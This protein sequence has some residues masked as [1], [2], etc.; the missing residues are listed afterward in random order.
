M[1]QVTKFCM[2]HAELVFVIAALIL[3]FFMQ[4]DETS[5][6]LCLFNWL[7]ISW[8]PGCG[9]GHSIHYALHANFAASVHHHILGIPAVI[10]ML[11]R[12]RK[13]L[14]IHKQQFI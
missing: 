4:A 13:L 7:G 9:L 11:N 2:K 1:I 3:L 6:S 8:C 14:Y 10:L 12:V 5:S